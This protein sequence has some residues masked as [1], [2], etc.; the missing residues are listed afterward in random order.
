MNGRFDRNFEGF[1]EPALSV[2]QQLPYHGNVRELENVIERA[3][4]LETGPQITATYLPDPGSTELV[5]DDFYTRDETIPPIAMNEQQLVAWFIDNV[6]RNLEGD[7][8][9]IELEKLLQDL[10]R[11][12]MERALKLTGGNKTD[13]AAS[14]GMSF[15]SFRYKLSKLSDDG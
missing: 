15:R 3:V 2:L 6:Q 10:E 7:G 12:I 13:A 9:K 5:E 4:A 14:V 8:S 11:G 1:S